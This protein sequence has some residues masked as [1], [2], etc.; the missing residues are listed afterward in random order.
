[1]GDGLLLRA[2]EA[3]QGYGHPRLGYAA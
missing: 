1:M 2:V 3:V